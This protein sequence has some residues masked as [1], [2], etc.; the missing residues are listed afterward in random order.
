[1]SAAELAATILGKPEEEGGDEYDSVSSEILSGIKSN[2]PKV[3]SKSLKAFVQMCQAV[4]DE[5]E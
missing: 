1:M 2:D 3:F 4:E 5:A